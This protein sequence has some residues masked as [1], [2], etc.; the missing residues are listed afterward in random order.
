MKILI[1]FIVVIV[2][3]ALNTIMAFGTVNYDNVQGSSDNNLNTKITTGESYQTNIR[4]WVKGNYIYGDA[5]PILINDRTQV[6]IRFISQEL[7]Y[8]VSWTEETETIQIKNQ[9]K[10]VLLKVNSDIAT[11][12]GENKKL[13]APVVIKFDRSYV[14]LRFIAENFGENVSY[15][16]NCETAIVGNDFDENES[17]PVK[18]FI[19]NGEKFTLGDKVNFNVKI[20]GST[21]D[22]QKYEIFQG[23]NGG[24][25]VESVY[26]AVIIQPKY[27]NMWFFSEGLAP[28]QNVYSKKWGF[29]DVYGNE[30]IPAKYSEVLDTRDFN[31]VEGFRIGFVDGIAKVRIGGLKDGRWI[32]IDN[33]GREIYNEKNVPENVKNLT[34]KRGSFNKEKFIK[35]IEKELTQSMSNN[36]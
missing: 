21:G 18:R 23:A 11:V 26:G 5:P 36:H 12:D 20:Q 8:K 2:I 30:V 32:Y 31:K 14:P 34:N 9:N 17:Y 22:K 28:F 10:E 35:K 25:G 16:L 29:I 33:K 6:P 27:N 13:D 24:W 4:V 3:F 15:S 1:K 7:G 19:G